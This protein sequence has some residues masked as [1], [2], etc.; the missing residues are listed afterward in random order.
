MKAAF[1]DID[2][3]I[4][5]LFPAGSLYV[6]GAE[7]LI[8]TLHRLNHYAGAHGI[9]L[10]S[11]TCAHQEDDPEFTQWPA[12]CVI[13]TVGQ[14]KPH[15]LLLEDRA[16]IGVAPGNYPIAGA[17]QILFE[18]NQLDIT[19]SPNFRPLLTQLAAD[20]Y[21]VYGVV[22]EYC[23]RF[24]ALALLETGKPVSLVA[25]AIQTLNAG[26]SA[27]MV[28]EFT[29]RGGRLAKAAEIWE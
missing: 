19:T 9:P 27:E 22:T 23:V 2:T 1:F 21:V 3:Q 24:A 7:R 16:S 5:F 28:R 10:I 26:A 17:R 6:P 29:G 8:P 20:S 11:S 14:L 4:D 13:G 15:E 12:H 18:K 25:D